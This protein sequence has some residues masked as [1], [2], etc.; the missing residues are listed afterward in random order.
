MRRDRETRFL[1]SSGP[2]IV[3]Q[4][5]TERGPAEEGQ[6]ALFA[7]D[8]ASLGVRRQMGVVIGRQ[9]RRRR[10]RRGGRRRVRSRHGR[11]EG[12]TEPLH[13]E[14]TEDPIRACRRWKKR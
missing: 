5:F 4:M 10:R 1:T 13:A 9:G 2:M 6:S 14:R 3:L 11:S 8:L 12:K 7:L